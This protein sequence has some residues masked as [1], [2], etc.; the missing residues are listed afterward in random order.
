MNGTDRHDAL[1]DD[2]LRRLEQAAYSLTPERRAELVLEIR[3]HIADARTSAEVATDEAWTRT[4][5]DRLGSPEEIVA[6]AAEGEPPPPPAWT[7]QPPMVQRP[8]GT[9][10]ELAAVLLLTVGSLLP[11]IGWLAGVICLWAS[12]RWRTWEK[13]LGTLI[14]PGGPVG[15][16]LWAAVIIPG[17]SCQQPAEGPKTCT[18]FALH[19]AV[20]VPLFLFAV[21][22]PV[23]V[24]G[25]LY[26]KARAR[27]A[28]EP[29]TLVMVGPRRHIQDSPWGSV[30]LAAVLLLAAGPFLLPVIGPIIGLVLVWSSQSWTTQE[31]GVATAIAAS[32]VLLPF[33]LFLL[34][35][36]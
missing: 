1:V 16:G 2:Y 9:G 13:L 35:V 20:G 22:A 21:I 30:E 11:V 36:L 24:A 6:A 19:P 4:L 25:W 5:L 10:L 17:Q 27:A 3:D 23:V 8:A 28:M 12:R 26:A 29:P 31:K 15:V 14:I 18:G 34:L 33:A 7:P 32:G